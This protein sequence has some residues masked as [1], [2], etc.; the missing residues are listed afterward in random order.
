MAMV[1]ALMWSSVLASEAPP[2]LTM[3][4]HGCG[5]D[6][7]L[8]DSRCLDRYLKWL[9]S[10]LDVAYQHALDRLPE[11]DEMDLRKKK[12]Q[13]RKSQR[14]WLQYKNDNCILVGGLEGGS[15]PN[16]TLAAML[17]MEQELKRR[18]EFLS[19]IADDK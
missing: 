13:L 9:D 6:G 10:Q 5:G 15:S 11:H 16:I 14:A 7:L 2:Y 8:D 17:C 18:I 3:V 19:R 4:D 12:E 1:C